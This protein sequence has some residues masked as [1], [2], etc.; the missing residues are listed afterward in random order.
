M[1]P[2]YDRKDSWSHSEDKILIESVLENARNN[3]PKM[4]AFEIAAKRLDRTT[5]ACSARWY[6]IKEKVV[7]NPALEVNEVVEVIHQSQTESEP[8]FI[9]TLLL[10][11]NVK[12]IKTM[13]GVYL[14]PDVAN[15]LRWLGKKGG[16]GSQSKIINDLLKIAFIEKGLL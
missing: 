5:G 10:G 4:N 11:T 2:M 9:D 15:V 1:I 8:E 7:S 6:Q 3:K 14:E 13:I 12:E 16:R